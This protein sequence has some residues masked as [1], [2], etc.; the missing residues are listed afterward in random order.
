MLKHIRRG[1]VVAVHRLRR[2][3]AEAIET[4]AHGDAK[5]S[6]V[7]GR[8]IEKIDM[9]KGAVIGAI[10]RGDQVIMAHHDTVIESERSHHHFR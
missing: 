8:S 1:D 7:I 6:K 9:P 2:G 3:V 10:V 4:I 5:S